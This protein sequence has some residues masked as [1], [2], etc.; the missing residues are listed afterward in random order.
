LKECEVVR[1]AALIWL[2]KVSSAL[3]ESETYHHQG[4]V[5]THTLKR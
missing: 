5:L 3:T 2:E 1:H 4:V